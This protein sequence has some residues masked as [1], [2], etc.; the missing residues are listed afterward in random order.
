[1]SKTLQI[2]IIAAGLCANENWMQGAKAAV[3][4]TDNDM[5]N[6]VAETAIQVYDA[7]K[8]KM[9]PHAELPLDSESELI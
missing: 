5:P 8:K 7:I 4:V 3:N 2:S 1:M 6:F 9:K